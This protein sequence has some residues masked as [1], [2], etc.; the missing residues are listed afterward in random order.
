MHKI[1]SNFVDHL[2]D[3]TFPVYLVLTALLTSPAAW[4]GKLDVVFVGLTRLTA[5]RLYSPRAVVGCRRVSPEVTPLK[6]T[7]VDDQP[8]GTDAVDADLRDDVS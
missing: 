1:G 5:Y 7:V 2:T 8:L 4:H 3:Q 6:Q